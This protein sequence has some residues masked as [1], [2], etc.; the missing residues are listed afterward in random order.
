MSA[1][2]NPL[3]FPSPMIPE[4]PEGTTGMTLRDWFA[5]QC[6]VMAYNPAKAYFDAHREWPSVIQLANYIAGIRIIEADA[7]LAARRPDLLTGV[8]K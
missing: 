4:W 7:M 5:G 1:P 8:A 3:A 6:D 2:D